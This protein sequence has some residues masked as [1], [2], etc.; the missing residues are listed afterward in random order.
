MVI[1]SF[2]IVVVV[3]ELWFLFQ[4]RD[5]IPY[6]CSCKMDDSFQAPEQVIVRAEE[7]RIANLGWTRI[8]S[9]DNI[10]TGARRLWT[11]GFT[12]HCVK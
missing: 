11:S 10:G 8:P 7:N 9:R 12:R 5:N 1:G 6:I 3:H 4:S 2:P